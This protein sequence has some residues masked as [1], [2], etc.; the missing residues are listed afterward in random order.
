M[1][2]STEEC[3]AR[4]AA[5]GKISTAQALDLLSD[6]ADRAEEMRRTGVEDPIV[7]AA[8]ELA[9]K[10]KE[11]A[12]LDRIDA[13]R[14]AT[15]R[16]GIMDMIQA[17]GGLA[18]ASDIIRSVLHGT[19][20]FGR[21]S[22]ESM[23]HGISNGWQAALDNQL[24]K[25][26]LKKAA[27][28]GEMDR[29]I[30][31]A[32][33]KINAGEDA[34]NGP[35]AQVAKLYSQAMDHVRER[36]NA[37]GARIADASDYVTHTSHDPEKLRSAAGPAKSPGE[38]FAAWWAK[39]E[40]RLSEKTFENVTPEE[41]E[42][43]AVARRRFGRSVFDS[44][45]TGVH[46]TAA[47]DQAGPARIVFEGTR[48]LARKVSQD[49]T[50]FWKDG[51]GWH[52]YMQD[53]GRFPN[54]NASVMMS[55]DKGARQLALMDKLGTNPA[56]NLNQIIRRVEE[57]YRSD[58][59][60]LAKFRN[61][62]Q[63][64]LN[65]MGR[66][67]GSLNIPASMDLAKGFNA[68]RSWES[69]SSLGGVGITHF[70][71]I[72]PTVTSELAHHGI[73]RLETLGNMMKALASG[74]GSAERREILSDLG[75]YADGIMRH[76]QSVI[77]DDSIP[78]RISA[79]ASRFMDFTG[80][81][82]VFDQT[83]A[84]VR[85]MLAHNLARNLTKEFSALDPNLSLLLEKYGIGEEG[86]DKLR[87]L[88]DLPTYNGRAYL[89]PSAAGTVDP[90][91]S[92]KLLSYY[93]DGAAH[94][95]V[96]A[97]VRER[98]MMLGSTRPG[99]WEGEIMRSFTQ[100]KM[101]PVAAMTQVIGREIYT[102][103]SKQ[104]AAWNLGKLIALG[105]PAGYLRMAINDEASGRPMRNPFDP[106]TVLAA[107][108]QSGG[109]GILGDFLFGEANR[110]GGGLVDTAGGPIVSDADTAMKLFNDWRGGKAGWGEL[111]HF[112]VRHVP[113]ANLIYLKGALDY[114]LWYHLYEAASP[115]WWERSNRRMIKEQGRA[116]TGYMPGSGIPWSPFAIGQGGA[117][118][119]ASQ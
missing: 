79:I 97:G 41:G 82:H 3:L 19:N 6:V 17:N 107:L 109:V 66:L 65:V 116:M 34:G 30:S 86:W 32:W 64:L 16:N 24:F 5:A 111:A 71:S 119:P 29:D 52:E 37:V 106:R 15:K 44:L 1:A 75:A 31:A 21:D 101:W 35:P 93:G 48:N 27:Q 74:K 84:G 26:G 7:T 118:T 103:L 9:G 91:L 99:T 12:R 88:T 115:G 14:N 85:D 60:G 112:G 58:A 50:L 4:I 94:A 8:G 45:L 55:I 47:G 39:T 38:A 49:R 20:K 105:I 70:A 117:F 113:F 87:T 33:W 28:T 23:W 77:G 22:I 83:K 80:I 78:G 68:V 89:T 72:W 59:D 61:K 2:R 25:A 95:V 42:T 104:D 57:E 51:E 67:D 36:L 114:L 81:H 69:M 90:V 63:G 100:F 18:N 96:T 46:M 13:L 110:M 62:T 10:V 11:A 98:A 43:M 92:D 108:A 53:F 73:S 76:T 54:L 102:S 40:P 56:A